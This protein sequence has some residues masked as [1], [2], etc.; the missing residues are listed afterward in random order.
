[1]IWWT[2]CFFPFLL[3]RC[4]LAQLRDLALMDFVIVP[5]EAMR[6]N[7]RYYWRTDCLQL[8]E[9][10]TGTDFGTSGTAHQR[11]RGAPL[12]VSTPKATGGHILY[13]KN[14][15]R[16]WWRVVLDEAQMVAD[17]SSLRSS[18]VADLESHSRWC[19]SGTP[20]NNNLEDFSGLLSFISRG[21]FNDHQVLKNEMLT[22]FRNRQPLGLRRMKGLLASIMW[23]HSK[24]RVSD[25]LDKEEF[26]K[27]P[28]TVTNV[29]TVTFSPEER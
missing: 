19:V 2:D 28:A 1:L 18:Y 11:H 26:S 6:H 13:G 5:F 14:D 15:G 22:P 23:R 10:C 27:V 24:A 8:P 3:H 9:G 17:S 4:T 29:L 25:E 20:L 7:N 12:S 21:T 16:Q